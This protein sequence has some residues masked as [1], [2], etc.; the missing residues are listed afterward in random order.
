MGR[1]SIG[2]PMPDP[3]NG[4]ASLP[5]WDLYRYLRVLYFS[6]NIL[7]RSDDRNVDS[8]DQRTPTRISHAYIQAGMSTIRDLLAPPESP[9]WIIAIREIAGR[10]LTTI[11]KQRPRT[12]HNQNPRYRQ[13]RRFHVRPPSRGQMSPD[14]PAGRATHTLKWPTIPHTAT[15]ISVLMQCQAPS[16]VAIRPTGPG[17]G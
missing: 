17:D 3:N 12:H 5:R 13:R 16:I 2:R 11:G 6:P 10:K 4:R 14:A 15:C 9:H 7:R 1:S 8:A